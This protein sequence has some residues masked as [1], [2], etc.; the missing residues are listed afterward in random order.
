MEPAEHKPEPPAE[1]AATGPTAI[2][3]ARPVGP[4]R[5]TSLCG[6]DLL[7]GVALAWGI[8]ALVGLIAGVF[9]FALSG[10]QLQEAM[11]LMPPEV[12]AGAA[13][14]S[15]VL[16]AGVVW[17]LACRQ[18]NKS[19]Q[20]GFVLRNVGAPVVAGSIG[21]GLLA[22]LVLAPLI[23]SGGTG[24]S[25][26]SQMV[27]QERGLLA[28]AVLAFI[29]PPFEELYYRGFIYPVIARKL[30]AGWAVVLV[31]LWFG[32]VHVPQ[33]I[34]DW[35]AVAFVVSMGVVWT[36]MRYATGSLLPSL[37]C[38]WV[39]NIFLVLPSFILP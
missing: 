3:V 21:V 9:A 10:Y 8:E 36:L 33:L 18:Y 12:I 38:H 24:D 6:R 5:P 37:I 13:I 31:S 2:P 1:F 30:G 7:I 35:T 29:V 11:E 17:Y 34:G 15:N 27:E 19:F 26:M 14:L 23:L 32:A 22:S 4:V 28:L 20:D 25:M 16:T 39:Y